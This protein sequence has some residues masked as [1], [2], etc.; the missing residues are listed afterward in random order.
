VAW[1][2]R[3]EGHRTRGGQGIAGEMKRKFGFGKPKATVSGFPIFLAMRLQSID[4]FLP[5]SYPPPTEARN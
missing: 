5:A 3:F 4:A 2:V 1:T